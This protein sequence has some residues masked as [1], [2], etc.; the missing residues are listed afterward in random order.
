M[1]TAADFLKFIKAIQ[2]KLG[3][4]TIIV[5]KTSLARFTYNRLVI[6]TNRNSLRKDTFDVRHHARGRLCC[7]D[8][9]KASRDDVRLDQR[10]F[11]CAEL[12]AGGHIPK[13]CV[14]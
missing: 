12:T 7:V 8:L 11:I 3:G 9:P 13:Y 10:R 6:D 5:A 1:I 4:I 14:A 2:K